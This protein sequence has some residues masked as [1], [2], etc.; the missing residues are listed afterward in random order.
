MP[1]TAPT[2]RRGWPQCLGLFAILHSRGRDPPRPGQR[3]SRPTPAIQPDAARGD[4][5]HSSP[6][7]LCRAGDLASPLAPRFFPAAVTPR[8]VVFYAE[9]SKIMQKTWVLPQF[10][11]SDFGG[12]RYSISST[13]HFRYSVSGKFRTTGWSSAAPRRSSSRT[14]RCASAAADATAPSRSAQPT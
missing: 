14:L 9:N 2:G 4:R 5:A 1:P 7:P 13:R 10:L 3:D 11:H 8:L 6:S 12:M